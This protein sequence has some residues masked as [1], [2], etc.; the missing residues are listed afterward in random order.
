MSDADALK[1]LEL[2]EL[3]KKAEKMLISSVVA[4]ISEYKTKTKRQ[5]TEKMVKEYIKSTT[6][7]LKVVSDNIGDS[8]KG[9]FGTKAQETLKEQSEKLEKF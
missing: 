8:L 1:E 7:D 2:L 5:K 6:S 4:G 3:K 9:N